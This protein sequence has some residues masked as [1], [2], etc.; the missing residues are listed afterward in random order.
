M[1]QLTVIEALDSEKAVL[2]YTQQEGIE[3]YKEKFRQDILSVVPDLR[4]GKSRDAIKSNAFKA[5]KMK[6]KFEEKGKEL[7]AE[8]KEI[9]KKIDAT[10]KM[11]KE[12]FDDV[13]EEARRPLTEWE[14]EEALKAEQEKERKEAEELAAKVE[15]EHELALLLHEKWVAAKAKEEADALAEAKRIQDEHDA[16]I[17]KAAQEKEAAE[18]QA[19]ID[20]AEKEKQEAI[21]AEAKA[22]QDLIDAEELRE[23]EAAEAESNRKQAIIDAE[24]QRIEDKKASDL[25]VKQ[26]ADNE[27]KR[28]ADEQAVIEADRIKREANTKHKGKINKA[29][30]E[31]IVN[32][33]GVSES[34]A[35]KIV[36][37]IVKGLIPSVTIQY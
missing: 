17:A 28:I 5:N 24:N 21:D 14:A 4:T 12:F 16:R 32:Q 20:K 2:I 37:A 27:R 11:L 9:P 23:K 22:K 8:Y 31:A 29:A 25:A 30:L 34:D 1:K 15:A 33:S 19:V 35:K 6:A 7:A 18:K 3:D 26:A 10:R 13:A 36:S